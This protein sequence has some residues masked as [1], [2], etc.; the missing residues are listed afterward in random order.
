MCSALSAE[1]E[2]RICINLDK[3]F[4]DAGFTLGLLSFSS[5]GLLSSP[6]QADLAML[7]TISWKGWSRFGEE[8]FSESVQKH[9]L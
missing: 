8:G 7:Y 9:C 4:P 2:E 3:L 6:R 5:P 1:P